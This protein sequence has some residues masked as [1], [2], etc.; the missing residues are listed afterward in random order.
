VIAEG[1]GLR[2][3]KSW[4]EGRRSYVV[5]YEVRLYKSRNFPIER[6]RRGKH[7]SQAHFTASEQVKVPGIQ[8]DTPAT[9]DA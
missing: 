8:I 9:R 3:S 2:E 7:V 6:Q 1:F 5:T 4:R